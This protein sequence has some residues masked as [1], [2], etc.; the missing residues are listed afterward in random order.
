M[1]LELPQQCTKRIDD[2]FEATNGA[3]TSAFEAYHLRC[4]GSNLEEVHNPSTAF[5]IDNPRPRFTWAARHH[6]R[7][8]R[9]AAYR[10]VLREH[11]RDAAFD[12]LPL[13]FDSG[14]LLSTRPS[15]EFTG[16]PVLRSD[17]EY[18]WQVVLWDARGRQSTPSRPASF[19]FALANQTDWEGVAWVS[20]NNK[21]NNNLLRSTFNITDPASVQV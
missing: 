16:E 20:G 19:R 17:T 2:T 11:R 4:D 3:F 10:L 7:G 15:H 12:A 21:M 13:V 18:A 9:Q 14:R 6:E 8:Q 5:A 1:K